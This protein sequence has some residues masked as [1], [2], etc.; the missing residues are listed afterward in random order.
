VPVIQ[1]VVRVVEKEVPVELRTVETVVKTAVQEVPVTRTLVREV[2]G[3]TVYVASNSYGNSD[4]SSQEEIKMDNN[5]KDKENKDSNIKKDTVR[6]S[7]IEAGAEEK[8]ATEVPALGDA[9]MKNNWWLPFMIGMASGGLGVGV[10]WW[11]MGRGRE[12]K[13]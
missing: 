11:I 9:E 7:E 3:R 4:D 5:I 8:E 2:A 6:N 1:E 10:A 12:V 13:E